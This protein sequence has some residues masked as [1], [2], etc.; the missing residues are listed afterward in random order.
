VK[1]QHTVGRRSLLSRHRLKGKML[2]FRE[3]TIEGP[4]LRHHGSKIR[5]LGVG[6]GQ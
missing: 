3:L 6:D 4:T 2:S 5:R 1:K